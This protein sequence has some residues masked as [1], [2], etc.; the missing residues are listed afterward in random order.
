MPVISAPGRKIDSEG[1]RYY[2]WGDKL[3]PSVTTILHDAVPK[4][5]LA[6]WQANLIVNSIPKERSRIANTSDEQIRDYFHGL[7]DSSKDTSSARGTVVHAYAD[8]YATGKE[9]PTIADE[10][11]ELVTQFENF[12]YDWKPEFLYTE[13]PVFSHTYGYAGTA[14]GFVRIKGKV[15]VIDYKTGNRI[16]PEVSLQLAAYSRADFI[17]ANGSQLEIPKI[18]G[19]L[20]LHLRKDESDT[21]V[22]FA[23]AGYELRR[24]KIDDN[25]FNAFLAA[26]DMFRFL[27]EDAPYVIQAKMEV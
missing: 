15:Y 24:V 18:D 8:S 5:G 19:G 17:G 14:D 11:K 13:A 23:P 21:G 27:K 20:V 26:L 7:A 12:C 16:W 1:G 3:Y 2:E 6:K 9:T 25:V 22:A 4:P 10:D